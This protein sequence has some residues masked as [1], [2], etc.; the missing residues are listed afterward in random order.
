VDAPQPSAGKRAAHRED[1]RRRIEDALLECMATGQMNRLNHDALAEMTGISRRTVYR[2]FPDRDALMKALWHRTMKVQGPR[3]GMPRDAEA[4]LT[5]LTDV[6]TAYD[7]NASAMIVATST[8]EG[9]AVRNAAK[10]EREAG[11]RQALAKETEKLPDLD[12]RMVLGVIQL[13]STGL[14]WRELRDQ[15]DLDGAE[16]ATACR[17]A[18]ATLLRDL[19]ERGGRSLRQGEGGR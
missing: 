3:G 13:L 5:R 6:F 19:D 10:A 11:W 16:I 17:W 12:R 8:L 2:Y 18:I 14:A 9:R 7:R 4:V 1:I 15:W